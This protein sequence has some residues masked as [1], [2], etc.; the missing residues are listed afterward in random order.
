MALPGFPPPDL[1]VDVTIE[2]LQPM[3]FGG[4]RFPFERRVI[5]GGGRQHTHVFPHSHGGENE[6]LGR[7]L[8]RVQVFSQFHDR[9]GEEMDRIY[10]DLYPARLTLLRGMFERQETQ[11][12]VVPGLGSYQAFCTNWTQTLDAKITSGEEV[13]LEFLEDEDFVPIALRFS[14]QKMNLAVDEMM[15]PLPELPKLPS[16]FQQIND[17]VG[18]LDQIK[19]AGDIAN[20]LLEAKLIA[21]VNLCANAEQTVNELQ[22]PLNHQVFAALK[23]VWLAATEWMDDLN[24]RASPIHVWT[25]QKKMSVNQI[26]IAIYQDATHIEELLDLNAFADPLEVPAGTPVRFYRV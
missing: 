15:Q 7:E 18:T 1:D 20:K 4:I 10:P 25:T 23:T 2:T 8:Y 26:S 13:Q 14:Q 22:D 3:E 19:A 17:L 11:R 5:S 24:S 6:K 21:L 16:I 12:L 9:P